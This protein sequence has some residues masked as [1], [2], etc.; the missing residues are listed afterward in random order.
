MHCS[1]PAVAAFVRRTAVGGFVQG[2]SAATFGLA[3]LAAVA[4]LAI[5][6]CGGT[7]VPALWWA[8]LAVPIVGAGVWRALR[9]RVSPAVAACHLDRRLQLDGLLVSA[10]E[11]IELDAGWQRLLSERL[12]GARAALPT[13]QWGS[14]VPRAA[15]ASAVAALLVLWPVNGRALPTVVPGAFAAAVATQQQRLQDVFSMGLVPTAMLAELAAKLAALAM[16]ALPDDPSAWRELDSFV[17]QLGREQL[18]ASLD[19]TRAGG[20]PAGEAGRKDA[21]ERG[22]EMLRTFV[23]DPQLPAMARSLLEQALLQVGEQPQA[24][25]ADPQRL[26][27]IVEQ[28]AGVAKMLGLDASALGLAG[29]DMAR[30]QTMAKSLRELASAQGG[31]SA[32]GDARSNGS[33]LPGESGG[34][35]STAERS[36]GHTALRLTD[37]VGGRAT[38]D[39]VLP[40]GRPV[41]REWLPVGVQAI[42]PQVAPTA[43]GPTVGGSAVGATNGGASWQLQVAPR[44]RASVQRFFAAGQPVGEQSPGTKERR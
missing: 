14:L 17:E 6:L 31:D 36:V 39:F 3:M 7:V 38:K 40:E 29:A 33:T 22:V 2:A 24:L 18:L 42:D 8:V 1:G 21:I 16:S 19:P 37:P 5:R 27:Q 4:V 15:T 11:G 28:V 35:G 41:P 10:W 13:V 30:A 34:A 44:H 25:L 9:V 26:R 32:R 20:D 12:A 43:S 23:D